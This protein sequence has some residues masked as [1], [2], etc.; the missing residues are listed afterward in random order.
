VFLGPGEDTWP[1]FL[2]DFRRGEPRARYTST[3]RTLAGLPPVRRDLIRRRCY[4]V[5]NSIVVTRGCPQHCDFCYKDA[6]FAGGRS[7]YT[8]RVDAALAEIA[9]DQRATWAPWVRSQLGNIYEVRGV[10]V[11]SPSPLE[12]LTQ[13]LPGGPR[14]VTVVLDVDRDYPD[15]FYQP[16]TRVPVEPFDGR[17]YLAAPLLS[18][19]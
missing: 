15:E 12:R 8:Q 13:R 11:R 18:S 10:A 1:V 5:P 4:L 7:F 16:T 19:D 14:E 6:F 2:E 3:G 9:P 17:W